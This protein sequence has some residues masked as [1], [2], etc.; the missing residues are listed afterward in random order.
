[1]ERGAN[2]RQGGLASGRREPAEV[3]YLDEAPGQ[4]VGTEALG[5]RL[6]GKRL[7]LDRVVVLTIPPGVAHHPVFQ[8]DDAMIADGDA[9]GVT[10]EVVQRLLRAGGRGFGIDDPGANGVGPRAALICRDLGV[11]LGHLSELKG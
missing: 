11:V 10:A 4:D 3:A 7:G 9:V 2:G 8:R 1:M 6:G 5:E